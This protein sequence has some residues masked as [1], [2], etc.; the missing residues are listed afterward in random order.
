MV[1]ATVFRKSPTKTFSSW[2]EQY[3]N[4]KKSSTMQA[5]LF[6]RMVDM[7]IDELLEVRARECRDQAEEDDDDQVRCPEESKRSSI[8]SSMRES[9]FQSEPDFPILT[10]QAKHTISLVL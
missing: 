4:E 7:T 8:R 10:V 9:L 6:V 1:F 2:K 5:P 3:Q